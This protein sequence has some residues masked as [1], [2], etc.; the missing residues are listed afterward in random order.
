MRSLEMLGAVGYLGFLMPSVL[1]LMGILHRVHSILTVLEIDIYSIYY[2]RSQYTS[3]RWMIFF[4]IKVSYH[5]HPYTRHTPKYGI[6]SPVTGN[7]S[8]SQIPWRNTGI[9]KGLCT[10]S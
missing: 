8:F 9:L 10:Q 7:A 4:I 2:M 5:K 6:N 3:V 1:T